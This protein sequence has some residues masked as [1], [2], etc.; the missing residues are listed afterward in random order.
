MLLLRDN[1]VLGL[2]VG[3]LDGGG[4]R[5][6]FRGVAGCSAC[7]KVP[8][9]RRSPPGVGGGEPRAGCRR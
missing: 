2:D 5:F 4:N 3:A 6:Y 8:V 9:R 1:A 7:G